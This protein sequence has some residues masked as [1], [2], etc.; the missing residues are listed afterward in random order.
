LGSMPTRTATLKP[1]PQ[2][3]NAASTIQP[4]KSDQKSDPRI[5]PKNPTQDFIRPKTLSDPRLYP[6]QDFIRPKNFPR[7][8]D[9]SRHT[10]RLGM[11]IDKAINSLQ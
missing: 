10:Y 9:V 8:R 6:T 5:R 3:S 11:A 2:M 4:T 7:K 1:N